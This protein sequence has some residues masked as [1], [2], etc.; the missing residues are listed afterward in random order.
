[1]ASGATDV[2]WLT[3][4]ALEAGLSYAEAMRL[5]LCELYDLLTAYAV[6]TGRRKLKSGFGAPEDDGEAFWALLERR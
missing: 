6:R 5:P 2:A 3:V 1:M 4:A